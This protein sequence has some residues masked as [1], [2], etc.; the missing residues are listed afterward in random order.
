MVDIADMVALQEVDL[1]LDTI[2]RR[3]A[4]VADQLQ[5]PDSHGMLSDEVAAQ[6][7]RLDEGT[8]AR[9]AVEAEADALR[10]KIVTE[11]GKL[12]SGETTDAKELRHLQEEVFALRRGLKATRNACSPA[13]RRRSRSKRRWTTWSR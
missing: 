5:E 4:A 6:R 7:A 12:Y 10:A 9:K 2:K 11:D 1:R 3:L 8:L 13:S